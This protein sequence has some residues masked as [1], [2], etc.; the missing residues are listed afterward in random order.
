MQA[1]RSERFALPFSEFSKQGRQGKLFTIF[2]GAHP[3][4][5]YV[6]LKLQAASSF[7][8]RHSWLPWFATIASALALA[9]TIAERLDVVWALAAV[10]ALL[11][12]SFVWGYSVRALKDISDWP[13][14][15]N[16]QRQEY[17][18]VW[19]SLASSM[20]D[21]GAAAAGEANESRLRS[22]AAET[23]ANLLDLASISAQDEVLEIGCGVG[24]IGREIAGHCKS[25]TGADISTNMLTHASARLQSLPNTRLLLL[26]SVGL[27]PFA[28]NSVNVVYATNMLA[29]LDEMDRWRYV[30][31]A[32]RVLRPGGRIFLDNIDLESDAGWS[33]FSNDAVRYR[34]VQRPPYMPRFSTAAEFMAYV[35]RAGFISPQ[36][37]HR[38]PLVIVIATKPSG[39]ES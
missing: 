4:S 32:F 3:W 13:P 37:H 26:K 28:D 29:H 1:I 39:R 5:G 25:W 2:N 30:Q 23:V 38:S 8:R 7:L 34:S 18:A 22:S 19:D 6:K 9:V 14:L 12:S 11:G 16:W 33:M 10:V 36:A 31:E 21:A 27:E 20:N 24:R 35:N 17:A 15:S